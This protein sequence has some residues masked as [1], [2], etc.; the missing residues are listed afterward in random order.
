MANVIWFFLKW[1]I[2][3]SWRFFTGA[4]M[5]GKTYN[6]ATWWQGASSMYRK[7]R[8][9]YTWWKR[10]SRAKRA[11]WRHSVFWPVTLIILGFIFFGLSML[12]VLGFLA[13]G[14]FYIGWNKAR[15][16]LYNPVVARASDGTVSQVWILK[17]K[18]ARVVKKIHRPA[19]ERKRPGLAL[20]SEITSECRLVD[21]ADEERKII[22]SE[23]AEELDGEPPIEMK[24]LMMPD[25]DTRT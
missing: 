12:V 3:L 17:P 14:L 4:H 5:N 15:M 9:A 10:K 20:E 6:D 21:V 19:G 13:P 16:E 11:A 22:S 24:L 1:G 2:I 25:E 18:W 7:K 23:L 8:S